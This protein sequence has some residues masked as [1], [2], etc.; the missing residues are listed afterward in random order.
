MASRNFTIVAIT[1]GLVVLASAQAIARPL[2]DILQSHRFELCAEPDA[3]PFSSRAGER[4]GIF[5]EMGRRIA[6]ELG[7]DLKVTWITSRDYVHRTQCDAIPAVAVIDG[8]TDDEET[9]GATRAYVRSH[10]VLVV[11]QSHPAV[12]SINDFRTEHVAVPSGSWAHRLMNKAGIP[13]WVR[14]LDDP[15]ILEAVETGQADA[16][17]VSQSSFDWQVATHPQSP[18]RIAD[19]VTL[20]PSLDYTV[21]FGLRKGDAAIVERVDAL[22]GQ[23]MADGEL[24]KI[25]QGYGVTYLAP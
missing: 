17:I 16:G 12:H 11:A 4:P 14:F 22:I 20:D 9:K 8:K 6:Q 10:A 23:M 15:A 5:I 25:F 24:E 21:A 1:V 13:V 18:I 19:Q 3:L 7:V 2:A